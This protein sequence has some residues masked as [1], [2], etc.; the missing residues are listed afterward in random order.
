MEKK[1]KRKKE[2]NIFLLVGIIFRK[3]LNFLVHVESSYC[4]G[5]A[6]DPTW[7]YI[8]DPGQSCSLVNVDY[9]IKREDAVQSLF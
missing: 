7:A 4:Q 9:S 8:S 2:K 5:V 6:T 3:S 1:K